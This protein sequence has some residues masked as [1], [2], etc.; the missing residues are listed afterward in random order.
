ME[1]I[2]T[3]TDAVDAHLAA[4]CEP[5][6]QRRRELFA[7]AWRDDGH[8][9]DPPFEA[10]GIDALVD[11]VGQVLAAYPDHRFVRTTDV[12]AHHGVA[13]Y[14]W[15]LVSPAGDPAVAGTDVAETDASGRLVRVVG[16][17]GDLAP[18]A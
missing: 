6:P 3:I 10:V 16:F 5:D 13:R 17:F 11:L 1:T 9:I 14:G 18:A 12:D 7:T 8:L 15:A 2:N 4:Y